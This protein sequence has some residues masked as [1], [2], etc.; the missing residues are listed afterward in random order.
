MIQEIPEITED[1][2]DK[3]VIAKQ[4][5][6]IGREQVVAGDVRNIKLFH[7]RDAIFTTGLCHAQYAKQRFYEVKLSFVS[8]TLCWTICSCEWGVSHPYEPRFPSCLVSLEDL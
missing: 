4:A 7:C 3:S 8:G 5:K 1:F 6:R 2:I